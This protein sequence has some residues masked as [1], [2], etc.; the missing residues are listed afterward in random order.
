MKNF[1]T[2]NFKAGVNVSDMSDHLPIFLCI[3]H[4]RKK[5]NDLREC[6]QII[7]SENLLKLRRTLESVDWTSTLPETRPKKAY[8]FFSDI[9]KVPVKNVFL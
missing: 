6:F 1:E 9:I 3:K 4:T 5:L 2:D 8:E 7:N